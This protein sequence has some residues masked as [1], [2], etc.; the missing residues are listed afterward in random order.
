MR[1]RSTP[2]GARLSG[3]AAQTAVNTTGP[4]AVTAIVCSKCAA[5]LRSAVA[6]GAP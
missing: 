1:N 6:S 4:S 5:R 3:V 2:G